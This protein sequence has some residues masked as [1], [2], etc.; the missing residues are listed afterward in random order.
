MILRRAALVSL[1]LLSAACQAPVRPEAP[2]AAEPE[3][4]ATPA[5]APVR[6]TGARSAERSPGKALRAPDAVPEAA[7]MAEA[8][9]AVL[10]GA[11]V[12][13]R[14]RLRLAE[15]PCVQD[16]VVQRWEKVYGRW[17]PRFRAS[18]EA[19]LPL[20]A[21]VLDEIELHQ[22]PGEFALL[23]IVESWYR[24][25]AGSARG[26]YGMWQFTTTTARHQGLRIEPGFDERLAPQAS[27]RAAMRYLAA[28]QNEFGDWKLA[29]MAYNAGEFRVK[30][31]LARLAPKDRRV[32]AASHRPPG[33][34][35]TTYEHVAKVQA[36]ACLLAQ[37][38]RFGL[39]L[40][41][42][43]VVEPLQVVPVPAGI[44]LDALAARA[45]FST[46]ELRRLNPAFR[47]G[48]IPARGEHAVLLPRSAAQ[49]LSLAPS[50]PA[51]VAAAEPAISGTSVS[52]HRVESGD[53]LG[54]IARRY[55]IRLADLVRWNGIDVRALLHPGQQLRLEP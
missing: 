51:A 24:P 48:R 7:G 20:L 55:G 36:L 29:N 54:A 27:T 52:M 1:V 43:V 15:P 33:L 28:L 5:T 22:L 25:D 4:A 49:R 18:I 39:T 21:L 23:P 30:R 53:T 47:Q 41:D 8:V 37:P 34:S 14:L 40:P 42:E 38:Q 32:S 17:P 2:T 10:R 46:A 26:T 50:A 6:A 35:M 12:F 19:V 44:G 31:T 45:G 9:P 13:A 16:R 3:A 11:D